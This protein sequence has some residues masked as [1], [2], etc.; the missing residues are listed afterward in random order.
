MYKCKGV[1]W[2]QSERNLKKC[3]CSDFVLIVSF[4]DKLPYFD[5]KCSNCGLVANKEPL[6]ANEVDNWYKYLIQ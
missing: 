6:P 3:D 5:L 2:V 4:K 1:K